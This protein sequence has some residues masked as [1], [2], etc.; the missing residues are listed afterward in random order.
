MRKCATGGQSLANAE[1]GVGMSGFVGKIGD[2][3][4]ARLSEHTIY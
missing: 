3:D 1:R 2:K 4:Y